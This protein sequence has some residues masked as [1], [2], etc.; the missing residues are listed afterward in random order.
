MPT[1][2]LDAVCADAV[3][4]ARA[5]A[6]EDAPAGAVGEHLEAVADGERVVT[7]YFVCLDPAYVGWRWAVTVARASRAKAV[8][9]DEVQLVAGPDSVVAPPWVAWIDRVQPG[10]LGAGDVL[11]HRAVDP[12][13]VPGYTGAADTDAVTDELAPPEWE[14]GLGRARVLSSEGRDDAA[15]RWAHGSFGPGSAVAAVAPGR[16]SSC[17][18]LITIGGP[19]G[20]AF[21]ICAHR[22]SPADGHVVPLDFGCGAH[23][24]ATAVPEPEPLVAGDSVLEIVDLS[25]YEPPIT[26][27]EERDADQADADPASADGD[28]DPAMA[29]QQQDDADDQEADG[30]EGH[31]G[32]PVLT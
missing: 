27:A 11:P 3:D 4:L 22:L 26:P 15:D 17:G 20:Q 6:V 9:V 8:T 14:A 29:E 19:L 31:D 21:G 28:A 1:V 24:E 18:Y 10:D 2:V 25:T 13:L 30:T 12:M 32:D 5:A 7:H 16:C 23:S